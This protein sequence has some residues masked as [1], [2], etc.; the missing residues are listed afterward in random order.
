MDCLEN[1]PLLPI[2]LKLRQ[3]FKKQASPNEKKQAC[4]ALHD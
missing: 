4:G 3:N 2:S 1:F